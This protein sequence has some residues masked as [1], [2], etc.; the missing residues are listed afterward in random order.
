MRTIGIAGV[1]VIALGLHPPAAAASTLPA[2]LESNIPVE[3]I[4]S[5]RSAPPALEQPGTLIASSGPIE[6]LSTYVRAQR[7]LLERAWGVR[8]PDIRALANQHA[9]IQEDSDDGSE[10]GRV[11]VPLSS[12]D[13][14]GDGND[15]VLFFDIGLDE[16]S[17]LSEVHLTAHEGTSGAELWS[18]DFGTPF[19]VLVFSPGD[20]TGDGAEDLLVVGI[21]RTLQRGGLPCSGGLCAYNDRL[22]YQ[23]DIALMSG[24]DGARVW[25][26]SL[27]GMVRF[28][29][30]FVGQGPARQ[31]VAR[32]EGTNALIDLRSSGDHDGDGFDDF[33]F[34]VH[35]FSG[36]VVFSQ[37]VAS[38][39][40]RYATRAEAIAGDTGVTLLTRSQENQLGAALM[41]P[42]GDATGD[43]RADV[44]WTIPT[45]VAIP[46][47][48]AGTAGCVRARRMQLHVELIDSA[49][50]EAAWQV[51]LQDP[52]LVAAA[53]VMTRADLTGDDRADI[54]L[55]LGFEDQTQS[56]V[57]LSG[58]DGERL[59]TFETVITDP[60]SVLPS[61]DGGQGKDIL[62]WEGWE[63]APKEA[64]GIIFRIR[65]RRVDGATG[66]EIFSTQHDLTDEEDRLDSIFAYSVGDVDADG[67]ADIGHALWHYTPPW[68]P[69]GTAST[70]LRV[71]SGDDGTELARAERDR[72]SLLFIGGDWVPGGS[73]GLFEGSVPYNDTNF[74]LSAL[75][76]PEAT[77]LWTRQDVLFTA[78]FGSLERDDGD[79]VV[80][81]RT[82][83]VSEAPRW[84]SR[85]SVLRGVTG[86]EAW[87][88]G[89]LFESSPSPAPTPSETVSPTPSASPSAPQIETTTTS[90]TGRSATT[91]QYSDESFF[92]AR[93]TDSDGDPIP[94]QEITFELAGADSSRAVTATTDADGHASV[95]PTLQEKPGSH[96][97]TVR[98][99]GS[100]NHAASADTTT[101]IIEREDTTT[102][103]TVDGNGNKRTLTARMSDADTRND[104]VAGRAI[105]FYADGE[106]I[107]TSTTDADG[108]ATLK[109]PPR[110][111]GGKHDY[112]ARFSGDD[113]YRDSADRRSSG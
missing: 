57:A 41:L 59:W 37:Q 7:E 67:A 30:G 112:E 104:G 5:V 42:A 81:G 14:D 34:N 21:D 103:L 39:N 32:L 110:Y 68:E 76:M 24:P 15:D 35:D 78:L 47:M 111:R 31:E 62:F 52:G 94:D 72:K 83:F 61:L 100:E 48:C 98:Y 8:I 1:L 33:T 88:V 87:G 60:P 18:R 91:G 19:D 107:G 51:D 6:E 54:L 96:Q 64:P 50:Q 56:A 28:T 93:L 82:Q 4:Q 90:L 20:V 74:H 86:E 80:Y 23:W 65:L 105:D 36:E 84:R 44:L 106:L 101:F 70:I 40:L 53:P 77:A 13:L 79:D 75:E 85:I 10:G 66:S 108:I 38:E 2:G 25:D 29:G 27:D 102:E 43:G 16:N 55:G 9:E 12:N 11:R 26:R 63:P 113:Y 109:P 3:G 71:E 73:K 95:T 49:S 45:R 99:A 22:D 58:I 17:F 89:S 69:G 97:L 46:S 92:E